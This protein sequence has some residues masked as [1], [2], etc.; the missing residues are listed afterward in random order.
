MANW[1]ELGEVPDSEEEDG[2]DSQE[3][4]A[5]DLPPRT[6]AAVAPQQ[7]DEQGQRSHTSNT[8]PEDDDIWDIPD[9][10]DRLQLEPPVEQHFEKASESP[11]SSK[12]SSQLSS[13]PSDIGLP[14]V[15]HL[16]ATR[17]EETQPLDRS[18]LP[19]PTTQSFAADDISKSY[20]EISSS[21]PYLDGNED[22][23][24]FQGKQ[25]P[26][27]L[28][29]QSQE[30]GHDAS[31]QEALRVALQY[32]RSLRPRKPIQEHPYLIEN[33]QYSSILKRHGVRPLR[34]MVEADKPRN[35]NL[36]EDAD[37][38]HESQESRRQQDSQ[39]EGIFDMLDNTPII[40]LSSSLPE[41]SPLNDHA[42]QHSQP[43]VQDDT[44]ATSVIDQDL[45]NLENLMRQSYTASKDLANTKR[46]GSS[47]KSAARKRVRHDVVHSDSIEPGQPRDAAVDLLGLLS[48]PLPDPFQLGDREP[49]DLGTPPILR[50]FRAPTLSPEAQSPAKP[51]LLVVESDSED[52][53]A[54]K[55]DGGGI[56][57]D[58]ASDTES[59]SDSGSELVNKNSRRIRGVL[60]ASW[61]RIDM[62]SG[63]QRAEKEM[64]RHRDRT[65]EQ[66]QRRGVAQ[67]RQG[68][69]SSTAAGAAGLSTLDESDDED[70]T[71]RQETTDDTFHNQTSIILQ[72]ARNPEAHEEQLSDGDTSAVE[73]DTVDRML[74]GRK[75]QLK[76]SDSFQKSRKRLKTTRNP[77]RQPGTGS[78]QKRITSLFSRGGGPGLTNGSIPGSAGLTKRPKS[79]KSSKISDPRRAKAAR[80]RAA[81]PP[82]LSILDVIGPDAP[83]FLKVAA[84]TARRRPDQGRSSPGRK[85][86]RLAA[87]RDHVDAASVLQ[88]WRSGSIQPRSLVSGAKSAAS[89]TQRHKLQPL[90]ESSGNINRRLNAPL[91]SQNITPRKLFK[92]VS[93]GGGVSFQSNSTE[94]ALSM[95]KVKQ[96][97]QTH[98]LPKS[99]PSRPAQLETDGTETKNSF[100][101]HSRKRVLDRIYRRRRGDWSSASN[102]W[103]PNLV[104]ESQAASLPESAPDSAELRASA[105][106][107]R[108]PAQEQLAI[109]RRPRKK[110]KPQR[111]D[112]EAPE[113]SHAD[114][115]LPTGIPSVEVRNLCVETEQEKLV[116]LGPYGTHYTHHFEVFPFHRRVFFHQST[117][118]GSGAVEAVGNS[119]GRLCL[120]SRPYL[121]FCLGENAFR[122]GQWNAHVSSELGIVL[123]FVAEQIKSCKF[124]H[125][126]S[127]ITNALSASNFILNYV[128]DSMCFDSA[129][130]SKSFVLRTHEALGNFNRRV[131][132]C[133]HH[134][135][136][137][138]GVR[139][140]L[141]ARIYDRLLLVS[142]FTLRICQNDATLM[143]EQSQIQELLK[144]LASMTARMLLDLG[145]GHVR[146]TYEDLT[147]SHLRERGIREDEAPTM[148]SWVVLMKALEFAGVP[149]LSF[150][151]ALYG[152]LLTPE[153]TES[154]IVQDHERA[155]ENMFALLPL[156]EFNNIGVIIPGQR[157]D[158]TSDGWALPQ[159]L[160]RRVFDIYRRND[161]QNPSFNNYCK[162]LVGRCHYLVDQWGWRRSVSVIGVIFDFFGSQNL[163]HLRNE[164]VYQS[165]RFLEE[166]SGQPNLEIGPED[167]C[168]HV[169]LKLVALSIHRLRGIDASKD[170][171]NLVARVLPNHNR[172]YHKEDKLFQ[173][174]LAALRNHHDLLVTLFWA[175]PKEIRPGVTQIE[176]LV[177][178]ESSHQQACLTNLRA[179]SQLARFV[180]A[181]GEVTT[182]FKPL[183]QWRNNVFQKTIHQFDSAASDIQQQVL[184]MSKEL[185]TSISPDLIED[186]VSMNKRAVMDV[187][188]LSMTCSLDTMRHTTDLEA[189]SFALNILQLQHIFKHF[190]VAPPELDWAIL[191][192]S[193]ATVDLFLTRIGDFKDN[194]DSQQNESQ[195]LNS[196][197]A[198]DAVLVLEHEL[199]A[200]FFSMAR[201]IFSS[202]GAKNE[203]LLASAA[204]DKETCKEQITVLSARIAIRFISGG[205]IRLSDVFK[206]GKYGLF[207]G[208]TQRLGADQRK[209]LVLFVSEL[210]KNGHDDFSDVDFCLEELWALCIVKPRKHLQYETQLAE[211]LGRHS[212]EFVPDGVMGLA[213]KPDYGTN[214]ALF[215]FAISTMR[216]R[217][218][219]TGPTLKKLLLS[220]HGKTLKLVMEQIKGDLGSIAQDQTEH[221]SYVEFIRKI[222]ALIRAHGSDICMVD[223]YFYQIS[224][225]YSPSAQDPQ[226]QVA[227]MVSYGLRLP[228]GD[229]RVVQQLFYFLFNNVKLAIINDKRE[230]EASMLQHGMQNQ[231]IFGFVLGKMLPA[232]LRVA[233]VEDLGYTVADVY[234][235]ALRQKLQAPGLVH[236]LAEDD[237]PHLSATLKAV[238][239]GLTQMRQ[240]QGCLSENDVHT[241]RLLIAAL[242]ALWPSVYRMSSEILQCAAWEE[243]VSWLKL[244]KELMMAGE[245]YLA[246][247][248]EDGETVV[249]ANIMFGGGRRARE[250]S[251]KFDADV[252]SFTDNITDSIRKDW[253]GPTAASTRI[254]IQAPGKARGTSSTQ[255]G[256]GIEPLDWDRGE[257]V[258]DLH[259]HMREWLY[260][261]DRA[262]ETTRPRKQHRMSVIL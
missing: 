137:A 161:Q 15:S 172:Q 226:L 136:T 128:K 209:Y 151:D 205:L 245:M 53:A 84:R 11:I 204:T 108:V 236:E 146:K 83:R 38:Q 158:P 19:T 31:Q 189:A 95:E 257:L 33:A 92:T 21:R 59:G 66:E 258:T 233:C 163:A 106:S 199:A 96:T 231:G 56:I 69:P 73:V 260:W 60:P 55:Q 10:P 249:K 244:I 207:D 247:L 76:L 6:L 152:A 198:D 23:V 170:I 24:G 105:A 254:T 255:T 62:K 214:Q 165:P 90:G 117:L 82:Q 176:R 228:E 47:P 119:D 230:E 102:E 221:P 148:H 46:P 173:R 18:A 67:R 135:P 124:D 193:L 182:S 70:R 8:E 223:D 132:T 174:D 197:Q 4:Q 29:L 58:E 81:K 232:A 139:D 235:A 203:R 101:F 225:E 212:R 252:N 125:D 50:R 188:H 97:D 114:D 208:P 87:R 57:G 35:I 144:E 93:S 147:D 206:F 74:L 246:D 215:E 150:W 145:I 222:V 177:V 121:S 216:K 107:E 160:L 123:D 156:V 3:L 181:S 134:S 155:W 85:T 109:R 240:K 43:T 191:K 49:F 159:K 44:D 184:T 138:N 122:W 248:L 157:Q 180:V 30:L 115:P 54:E 32:E 194:E 48:S 111:L 129:S 241:T 196:A 178:P 229:T 262:F 2:F 77:Q 220:E 22:I 126:G 153:T 227:G 130:E 65:P 99:V 141:I 140:Q 116:G 190:A 142:L 131:L 37:F 45:P 162:A 80:R 201:C 112:I 36:S 167:R 219:E 104:L 192:V 168:F 118:L 237:L 250:G 72:P 259:E 243:V 185:S 7:E 78:D 34:A 5:C 175:S 79:K 17:R 98:R 251:L 110:T 71:A 200:S 120:D 239:E 224:R 127:V 187:L 41:T 100:I 133:I 166:L 261:W 242:T 234:V 9:S 61:L 143:Q 40:D 26:P 14:P 211:Q 218:R 20:V 64:R 253:I 63:L 16:F 202:R 75:R 195:L 94:P 91:S 149:G 154:S 42:R 113:Y 52:G 213:I 238:V 217:L 51:P 103:L 1:R 86:I 183:I 179:W 164:E 88:L 27:P 169:F 171:R 13:V 186:M 68:L 12:S 28:H 25:Q 89:R 256:Q 210:L 39:G